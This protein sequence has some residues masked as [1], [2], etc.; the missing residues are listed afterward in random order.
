MSNH[1][2]GQHSHGHTH[3]PANDAGLAETL[4]LDAAILGGYVEQAAQWAGALCT[5]AP[6]SILDLGTGTGVGALT[7]A[8]HFPHAAIRAIDRSPDMLALTQAAAHRHGLGERITTL[9]ADLN[10]AWPAGVGAELIWAALFLHELDNPMKALAQIFSALPSGG[11]LMLLEMEG[12]PSF[13]PE[14]MGHGSVIPNGLEARLHAAMAAQGWNH[15]PDWTASL[16][17]AGFAVERRDF[18]TL[19]STTAELAARYGRAFLTRVRQALG[20]TEAVS[21]RDLAALE[22]LLGDGAES[23]ERRGDLV[24]RGQ[25]TG[26]AARKPQAASLG[27]L[28]P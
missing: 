25:R 2:H 16:E 6:A 8:R 24:V 14:L 10:E 9:Q 13:L 23:L 19:G 12:L 4:E 7:L 28:V 1:H 3:G 15:H 27:G 20:E 11:L 5:T 18:P 22:L 21:P 17:A 26:W